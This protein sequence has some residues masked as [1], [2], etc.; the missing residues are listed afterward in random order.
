MI[1]WKITFMIAHLAKHRPSDAQ[2]MSAIRLIGQPV[3][4]VKRGLIG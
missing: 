1:N 3:P 2:K 4:N